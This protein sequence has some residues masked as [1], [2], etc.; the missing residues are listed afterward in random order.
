[1]FAFP[2]IFLV[3]IC[4]FMLGYAQFTKTALVWHVFQRTEDLAAR[5]PV[6]GV[7]KSIYG[8]VYEDPPAGLNE[9]AKSFA[10]AVPIPDHDFAFTVACYPTLLQIPRFDFGKAPASGPASS[11]PRNVVQWLDRLAVSV[12][13]YANK[14]GGAV[15]EVEDITD[16][17]YFAGQ[18]IGQFGSKRSFSQLQG[19]RLVA[20]W[21][22]QSGNA[23]RCGEDGKQVIAARAV[24][25]SERTKAYKKAG[26]KQMGK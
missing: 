4:G 9:R 12:R 19:T 10:F 23:L 25:W 8:A 1:M 7:V 20:S 21:A 16:D 6:A 26:F 14:A 13:E 2:I 5:T 3:L 22:L 15:D 24:A 18:L 17:A 11:P